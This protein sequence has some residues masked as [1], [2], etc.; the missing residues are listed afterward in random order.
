MFVD[1]I[2][3]F[4]KTLSFCAFNLLVDVKRSIIRLVQELN[5]SPASSLSLVSELCASLIIS[6]IYLQRLVCNHG[7]AVPSGLPQSTAQI[8]LA[9]TEKFILSSVYPEVFCIVKSNFD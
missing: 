5:Y 9:V 7:D 2:L 8:A 3:S 6:S 1:K 4:G